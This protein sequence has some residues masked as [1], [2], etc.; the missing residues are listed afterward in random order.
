MPVRYAVGILVLGAAT[1]F[2][3][4][5]VFAPSYLVHQG[6]P[7]DDAWIHQVY[8]RSLAT[9]FSLAYNPKIPATGA[10]SPMWA[11]I[12]S[13][14]YMFTKSTSGVVMS[15][16]IIGFL[17]HVMT[18]LVLF[19]VLINTKNSLFDGKKNTVMALVM[20]MLV[21]FHPDLLAASISGM[22]VPFATL[23]VVL[24]L[25]IAKQGRV[26]T[27]G[28]ICGVAPLVR[29]ELPILSFLFPILLYW[30]TRHRKRLILLLIAAAI[31]T[32]ISFGIVAVRNIVV[33][34]RPLMATFYAKAWKGG[35]SLFSAEF[36][37]F[38][39]L[40][41]KLDITGFTPLMFLAGA[42]AL[43]RNFTA[44]DPDNRV[45]STAMITALFFCAVSFVLVKPID[46]PAFYHQRYVMPVLP[47]MVIAI[48]IMV[49]HLLDGLRR[50]T[51]RQ[52]QVKLLLLFTKIGILVVMLMVLFL[53][54]PW[55]MARLSNDARNI[56]DVQVR[57]GKFLARVP[58]STVVW[59]VDAGAIRY[60]G[61]AFVVDMMGLN[62]AQ[63]LDERAQSYLD[64]H[65]PTYLDIMR[66]WSRLDPHSTRR[67]KAYLFKTS[68]AY[69]VTSFDLLMRM[70]WLVY[71][72]PGF[73]RGTYY[74]KNRKFSFVC[75]D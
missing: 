32:T 4:L 21:L 12:L 65:P 14:P 50:F 1:A 28:I 20:S 13:F 54:M 38:T 47:L 49:F 72:P 30:D 67:M 71:C 9:D 26:E 59:A 7:L 22:E 58:Q 74:I 39:K 48:P 36:T 5:M 51:S 27:Y 55:R 66:G 53:D 6:F 8:A 69:T 63:L 43:W 34:G 15:T 70:R 35:M 62:N 42:M 37:G 45:V 23:L 64:Q 61:N 33:S 56:D 73:G 10:T 16:K 60:F 31:G 3:A 29:P 19:F 18:V 41:G 25:L 68:T 75:A 40:L 11:L 52:N 17:F 24:L 57:M 2:G 44:S 46:P